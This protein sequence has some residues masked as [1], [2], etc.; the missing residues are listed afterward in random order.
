MAH[1]TERTGPVPH[2]RDGA[3]VRSTGCL[4]DWIPAA[5]SVPSA[6][7]TIR[8]RAQKQSRSAF[9]NWRRVLSKP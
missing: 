8:R 3:C 2:R 4:T 9:S 5:I 1:T 6:S 7:T